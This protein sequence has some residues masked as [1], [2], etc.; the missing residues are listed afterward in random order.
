MAADASAPAAVD[1]WVVLRRL[2]AENQELRGERDEL[3]HRI[4]ELELRLAQLSTAPVAAPEAPASR[5]VPPPRTARPDERVLPPAPRRRRALQ[6]PQL[7]PSLRPW[8]Q[9][10]LLAWRDAGHRGVV[11][12]VTGAGKT[13]VGVAAARDTLIAGGRVLVVV[14]TTEL[15]EQWF[16]VLA[17]RL[18]MSTSGA[19]AAAGTTTGPPAMSSSPSSTPRPAGRWARRRPT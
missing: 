6:L 1:P 16:R 19:S 7:T 12:A 17:E 3:R 2:M 4:D 15:Q 18:P 14:P 10:A 9:D 8:Q 5:V 11:E 13:L